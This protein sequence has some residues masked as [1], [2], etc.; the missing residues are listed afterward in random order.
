M[1]IPR[2]FKLIDFSQHGNMTRLRYICTDSPDEPFRNDNDIIYFGG[3]RWATPVIAFKYSTWCHTLLY[4]ER[5]YPEY[6]L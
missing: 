1:T 6:I 4:I 3:S 5:N 2:P